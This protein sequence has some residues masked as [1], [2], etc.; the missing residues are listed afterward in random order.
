MTALQL[1][2]RP[3]PLRSHTAV[4]A[5]D[6]DDGE[7]KKPLGGDTFDS[8]H[9]ATEEK[10]HS[11]ARGMKEDVDAAVEAAQAAWANGTGAWAQMSAT[12]RAGYVRKM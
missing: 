3:A 1:Q 4:R 6:A 12:E 7:Y 10:L 2:L 11:F 9:P 5:C 8:I